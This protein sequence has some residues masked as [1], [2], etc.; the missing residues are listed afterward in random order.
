MASGQA[1]PEINQTQSLLRNNPPFPHPARTIL[2]P[3]I[4]VLECQGMTSSV[5]VRFLFVFIERSLT[6]ASGARMINKKKI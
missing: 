5:V 6:L 2:N 3:S 4:V 1:R